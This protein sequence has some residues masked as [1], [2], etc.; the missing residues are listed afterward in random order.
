MCQQ[1]LTLLDLLFFLFVVAVY[2][3]FALLLKL[4][5]CVL[6]CFHLAVWLSASTSNAAHKCE[7]MQRDSFSKAPSSADHRPFLLN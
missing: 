7:F 1:L 6:C 3:P 4:F 2:V 5:Y